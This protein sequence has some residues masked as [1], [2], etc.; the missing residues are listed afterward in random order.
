MKKWSH[1]LFEAFLIVFS[2][3]FALSI[4]NYVERLKIKNQKTIAIQRIKLEVERNSR[5]L[6]EWIPKHQ[7]V[8]DL[9]NSLATGKNDTLRNALAQDKYFNFGI[10]TDEKQII[11]DML[12]NTA[13]DT[14]KS[15]GI[16]TEFDF[17]LV[18]ELTK[19]YSHQ[20][21]M[22]NGTLQNILTILMNQQT[23]DTQ[24][25]DENVKQLELNFRELTGQERVLAK[26]YEASL[27]KLI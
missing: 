23:Y 2:V 26:L 20:D 1:Y 12:S 5:I 16:I 27:M 10:L 4:E 14:A 3:L 25:L 6:V 11:N 7:K 13:W 24:R 9:L 21:L 15:T 19:V 22:M 18:E 17:E 8:Y